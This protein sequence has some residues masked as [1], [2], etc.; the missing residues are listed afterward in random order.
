[1][2]WLND[3]SWCTGEW[4]RKSYGNPMHVDKLSFSP[5]IQPKAKAGGLGCWTATR[6]EG[7]EEW[8]NC[9]EVAKGVEGKERDA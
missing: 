1:M 8:E 3:H 6:D 4:E 9:V 2:V 5:V 7:R